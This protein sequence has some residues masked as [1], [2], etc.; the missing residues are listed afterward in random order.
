MR[1]LRELRATDS[2]PPPTLSS[3]Q[4]DEID[5]LVSVY[6]ADRERYGMF[7]DGMRALVE[8]HPLVDFIHSH[9]ARLK[10]PDHLRDKLQRKWEKALSGEGQWDVNA[11]NLFEKV[12]D[13]AGLRILHLHTRQMAQI[14]THLVEALEEAR[15]PLVQ[16]FART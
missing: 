2:M 9:K 13:L 1:L 5:R 7:L 3:T 8:I 16:R 14:D 10:D 15:M 12:N 6:L 4:I 11:Q